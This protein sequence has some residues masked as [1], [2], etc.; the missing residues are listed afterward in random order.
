MDIKLAVML[1][2]LT[3]LVTMCCRELPHAIDHSLGI[4]EEVHHGYEQD[5]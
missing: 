4:P 5:H 2:V 3:V 1:T